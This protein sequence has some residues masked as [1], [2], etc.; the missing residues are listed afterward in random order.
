MCIIVSHSIELR[1]LCTLNNKVDVLQDIAG[2]QQPEDF[3]KSDSIPD[4]DQVLSRLHIGSHL[5]VAEIGYFASNAACLQAKNTFVN[6][7]MK[8]AR[9][10]GWERIIL[11]V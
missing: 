11:G 1:K 7:V 10:T 8:I 5:K 2:V 4:T 9:E 3:V 6:S